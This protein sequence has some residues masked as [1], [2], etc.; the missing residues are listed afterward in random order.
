[1]PSETSSLSPAWNPLS[2]LS[3]P[4]NSLQAHSDAER[5]NSS[6]AIRLEAQNQHVF[7]NPLL[8]DKKLNAIVNGGDYKQ[9]LLEITVSIFQDRVLLS[10]MKYGTSYP[11]KPEWV[12]PKHPSPTHDNGLLIIIKGDHCSKYARRICHRHSDTESTIILAVTRKV[13]GSPDILTDERLELTP[14]Y[15]CTVTESK[16]EKD[17]NRDLMKSVRVNK[18]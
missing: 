17:L 13:Q 5:A 3:P 16:T 11:L 15:L 14:D 8:A 12:T 6:S 4:A 9:K 2:R 10:H 18:K 7:I 1:M